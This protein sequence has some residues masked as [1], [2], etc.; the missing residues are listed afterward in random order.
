MAKSI[1]AKPKKKG[2][3]RPATGRDPMIG[4]RAGKELTA[5]IDK[6]AKAN[7]VESRSEAIRQ[8]VERAL[9]AEKPE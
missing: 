6:W 4:L 7:R 2:P 5:A 1:A 8:L 3:G 9:A